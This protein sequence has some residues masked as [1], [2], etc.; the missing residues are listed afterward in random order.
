MPD[1][2]FVFGSKSWCHDSLSIIVRSRPGGFVTQN[3]V[4]CGR[5]RGLP[6]SQ[7]PALV[8]RRCESELDQCRSWNGNYAYRCGSCRWQQ[9]LAA[10]VPN[11]DELFDYHGYAIEHESA[12]VRDTYDSAMLQE[13]LHA[14]KKLKD[15]FPD[16]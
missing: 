9:D 2:L 4:S 16:G 8:C 11:W 14:I 6:A 5:P 12:R 3:C 13:A 1:K 15:S 10:M 7:L